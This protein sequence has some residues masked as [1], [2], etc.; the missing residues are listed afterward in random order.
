MSEELA[1]L[2]DLGTAWRRV[3]RDIRDRVFI[4]HP[5]A[6]SLIELDLAGWLEERLRSV[7]DDNYAPATFR[8]AK[9]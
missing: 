8:K 1:E 4:R 9:A 7:R 3:K 2:F 6:V 5:Y